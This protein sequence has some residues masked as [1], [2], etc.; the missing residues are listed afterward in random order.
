[1]E[2]HGVKDVKFKGFMVDSAQA[3][4]NAIWEIFGS[5]DK[6]KPMLG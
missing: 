1:M 3:N 2:K 6:S 5:G 4:F